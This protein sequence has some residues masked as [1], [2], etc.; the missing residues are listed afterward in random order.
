MCVILY[1]ESGTKLNKNHLEIAYNNNPHG[2]GIMWAEDGRI[3]T[4]KGVCDFDQI[5]QIINMLNGMTYA[6]HFRWRTTGKISE[7]QCH[8]FQVLDKDKHGIDLCMM[9]NGTIFS[10]PQHPE[11]SDT[12]IFAEK[13]SNKILEKDPNF[14]FG[15]FHKLE[16]AVGKHNKMV[17]MSSDNRTFFANKDLGK[18]IDNVWF[19]NTY[20]LQTG[21]RKNILTAKE[22]KLE[23]KKESKT[24]GKEKLTEK[25]A[26]K[27]RFDIK[28]LRRRK[29]VN[30]YEFL[31]K[32]A[33]TTLGV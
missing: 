18:V 14:N 15:Y 7:E 11:K 25:I 27:T 5:W 30:G 28:V 31:N 26:E 12:Q 13:F 17:F 24:E 16:N 20:S 29:T 21:Y 9:H 8:P 22:S 2:Y 3:N 19:S 23:V 32:A 4:I 10:I 1:N 6:L 33:Y